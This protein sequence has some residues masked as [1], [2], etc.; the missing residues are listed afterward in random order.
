[1]TTYPAVALLAY[2]GSRT[3]V[4][5]CLQGRFTAAQLL[6]ALRRAVEEHGVLLTAERLQQEER[7]RGPRVHSWGPA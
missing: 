2:P 1:V 7:V 3:K 4:V 5:A 6:A